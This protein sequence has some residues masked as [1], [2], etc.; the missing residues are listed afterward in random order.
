MAT[1][2]DRQCRIQD[3]PEGVELERLSLTFSQRQRSRLAVMLPSGKAA[4]II[5]P[6]GE[7]LRPGDVLLSEVS[8]AIL[9]EAQEQELMQVTA[10]TTLELIRL[11]Y[12]LANR[13]VKAMLTADA[14]YIEP[15][16]I[17]ADMVSK[18]GGNVQTTFAIFE[19]ESGA[20]AAGHQ[21]S[22]IDDSDHV[23]GTIGE[24]LSIAAHRER[25]T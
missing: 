14:I 19:P 18:L 8:S 22:G 25:S 12:H 24:Q 17:L 9:I 10:S 15:D 1:L 2:Y 13:H 6:R 20:Y 23:M 16:P 4:A 7:C 3:I 5:L 21:H 11:V